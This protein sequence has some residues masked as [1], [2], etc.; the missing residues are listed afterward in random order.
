MDN[1][2][3][4][5]GDSLA[6]QIEGLK[7][8]EPASILSD[9]YERYNETQKE[10]MEMEIKKTRNTLWILATVFL[11]IQLI[12]IAQLELSI[13]DLW[14]EI[15]LFPVILAGLGFL[16]IK[17]PMVA[18]VV[19][20]LLIFGLW[21]YNV[22]LLGGIAIISGLLWKGIIISVYIV[23]FQHAN[24]ATKIKKELKL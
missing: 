16:A 8:E 20:G 9:E 2:T 18:V 19:A 4:K 10:I 3:T 11:V 1:E 7:K 24:T 21:I 14:L 5:P 12:A 23:C 6:D 22:I 17:E 13:S 15:L